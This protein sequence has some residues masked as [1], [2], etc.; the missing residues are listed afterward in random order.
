[1]AHVRLDG[2]PPSMVT[3]VLGRLQQC[4]KGSIPLTAVN[5]DPVFT[6]AVWGTG[7]RTAADI[8]WIGGMLG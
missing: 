1:M 2:P 5:T 4:V 8:N 3:F 6:L 7:G